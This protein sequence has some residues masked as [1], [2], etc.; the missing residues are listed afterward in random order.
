MPWDC[1]DIDQATGHFALYREP[2]TA[3]F[4]APLHNPLAHLDKIKVHSAL[5]YLQ[6]GF[7]VDVT[8]NHAAVAASSGWDWSTFTNNWTP[9]AY[10]IDRLLGTH[11]LGVIPI[12]LVASGQGLL[13]PGFPVQVNGSGGTRYLDI[14]VTATEVRARER[15][16]SGTGALSALSQTYK[17]IVL[18]E[19]A[20]I[21]GDV[22]WAEDGRVRGGEGM[23]DSD[24]HYLRA[25]ADGE[26]PYWLG[27]SQQIDTA[28]GICRYIDALGA[29]TH[30][31]Y[32]PSAYTGSLNSVV[33]RQ[34]QR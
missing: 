23:F 25:V 18:R 33:A 2:A 3:P 34:V 7:E 14:Y 29:M 15:V 1:F 11:N 27:A 10:T 28:G 16:D 31:F 5:A 32:Q 9:E 30:D 12:C 8:I 26:S 20:S 17:L 19:P 4:D 6:R 24:F 21:P 22:F 13:D